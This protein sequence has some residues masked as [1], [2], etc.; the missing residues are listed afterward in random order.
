L[1]PQNPKLVRVARIRVT[2][3]SKAT[4]QQ[5]ILV[6]RIRELRLQ[7]LQFAAVSRL[8]L[9]RAAYR[10]VK[11]LLQPRARRPLPLDFE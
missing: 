3:C 7:G 2:D 8:C 9:L 4:L 10:S 11:F 1:L 6:P 5:A